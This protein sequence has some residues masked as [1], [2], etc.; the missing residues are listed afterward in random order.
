MGKLNRR[1]HYKEVPSKTETSQ[2]AYM[3]QTIKVVMGSYWN[4]KYMKEYENKE[5]REMYVALRR[6]C[7]KHYG[8]NR[9]TTMLRTLAK[10]REWLVDHPNSGLA[11]IFIFDITP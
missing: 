3:L 8:N 2:T 9:R 4:R 6:Y 11:H 1:P 10:F 5:A 7:L